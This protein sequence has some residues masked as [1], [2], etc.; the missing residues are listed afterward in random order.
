MDSFYEYLLKSYI[1]FEEKS[2]LTMFTNLY[3]NVKRVMRK[4]RPLCN[5]GQGPHPFYVNVDLANGNVINHWID[6][7]QAAFPGV[8]VIRYLSTYNRLYNH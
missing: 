2:D 8:Q 7:L 6:S 1:L 3:A 5:E 4:G